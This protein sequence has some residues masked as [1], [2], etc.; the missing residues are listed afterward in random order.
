MNK[1]SVCREEKQQKL[2]IMMLERAIMNKIS[3]GGEEKAQKLFIMMRK[4]MIINKTVIKELH[5]IEKRN[6]IQEDYVNE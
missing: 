6:M 4:R 3:V 2:F 1:N 5:F